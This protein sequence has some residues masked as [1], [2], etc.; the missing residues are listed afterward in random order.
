[1]DHAAL[2]FFLGVP[3]LIVGT[4]GLGALFLPVIEGGSSTAWSEREGRFLPVIG[5]LR[6]RICAAFMAPLLHFSS[7]RAVRS[8]RGTPFFTWGWSVLYAMPVSLQRR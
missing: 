5:G 3:P 6:P 4:R 7:F 2:R 1:M 8:E